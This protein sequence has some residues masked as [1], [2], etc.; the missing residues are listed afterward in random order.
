MKLKPTILLSFLLVCLLAFPVY[1]AGNETMKNP[2]R[3]Q[4]IRPW[5]TG[6]PND[7][8]LNIDVQLHDLELV[9]QDRQTGQVQKRRD[10]R[11]AGG[12]DLHLHLLHH[13]VPG[14]QRHLHPAPGPARR[15]PGQGGRPGHHDPGPRPGRSP[16][17]EERGQTSSRPNRA[18][19]I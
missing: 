4:R 5:P 14:V 3:T 17:H 2:R 13:R 7:P 8:H 18:G 12:H 19:S 6:T 9:T 16:A 1:A 15:A 10:R 11:Q